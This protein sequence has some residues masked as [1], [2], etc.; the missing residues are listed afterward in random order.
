MQT[1]QC[2]IFNGFLAFH[3]IFCSIYF[4]RKGKNFEKKQEKGKVIKVSL[5]YFFG[6]YSSSRFSF[7]MVALDQKIYV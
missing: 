4:E 6:I 2:P 7:H 1:Q 3:S 5:L